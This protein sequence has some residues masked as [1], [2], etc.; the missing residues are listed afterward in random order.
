MERIDIQPGSFFPPSG[1]SHAAHGAHAGVRPQADKT[2][3]KS[4][5]Q[6]AFRN[7]LET[8]ADAA[9]A[10]GGPVNSQEAD[11]LFQSIQAAGEQVKQFPSG[12]NIAAYTKLVQGLVQRVVREGLVVEEHSS[13]SHILKRK[14]FSL[15]QVINNK[16]VELA[17][18][19]AATQREQF[20]LL[21]KV[22]EIQGLL[23]DL[24][25]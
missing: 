25:H 9:A 24:L 16:L 3:K 13:G 10:P 15:V 20:Q 19:V 8:E 1:G 23:V 12:E 4:R 18:G 6:K 11:E 7:L 2:R 21:A 14:S 5:P 17:D 22:E